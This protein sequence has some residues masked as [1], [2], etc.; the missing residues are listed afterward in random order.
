[1]YPTF[2]ERENLK[3]VFSVSSSFLLSTFHLKRRTD[4]GSVISALF[5]LASLFLLQISLQFLPV[6]HPL[7]AVT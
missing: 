6:I 4:K 2:E 5:L 3:F 1:M 7:F